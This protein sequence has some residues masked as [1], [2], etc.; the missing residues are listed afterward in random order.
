MLGYLPSTNQRGHYKMYIQG[1]WSRPLEILGFKMDF[2]LEGLELQ[3]GIIVCPS[4][5][6][7][8]W[9]HS[10]RIPLGQFRVGCHR[11]DRHQP[12]YLATK[13]DLPYVSLQDLE[14]E[15]HLIFRCPFF[16]VIIDCYYCL[17]WDL[18]SYLCTFF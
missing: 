11:L 12:P 14:T 10:L 6:W 9:M 7:R 3:D 8:H 2:Y 15:M 16:Y 5:T 13:H 1:Y 17:Y 18:G 4:Y